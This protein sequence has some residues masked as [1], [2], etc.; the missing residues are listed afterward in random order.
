LPSTHRDGKPEVTYWLGR[1]HWGQGLATWALR[2]LLQEVTV[3]PIYGG[4]AA[5]N[6]ASLRV[7]AKCGFKLCGEESGFA[8]ARGAELTELRLVLDA[9]VHPMDAAVHEGTTR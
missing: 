8:N 3:R 1:E 4:A 9:D 2:E 5:D 6:A 7:L